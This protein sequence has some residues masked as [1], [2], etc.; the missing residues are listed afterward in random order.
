MRH[1]IANTSRKENQVPTQ[2]TKS[3]SMTPKRL[4]RVIRT[5]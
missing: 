5:T 1:K 2:K 3:T 4:F